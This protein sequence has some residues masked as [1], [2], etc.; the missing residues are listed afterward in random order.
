M[1]N[2]CF[3]NRC[4]LFIKECEK[5]TQQ[6]NN[7]II[8][9]VIQYDKYFQK[10]GITNTIDKIVEFYDTQYTGNA[11]YIHIPDFNTVLN[12]YL[13]FPILSAYQIVDGEID[14]L[15]LTTI[16]NYY[17]MIQLNPYYPIEN[18]YYSEITGLI[19]KKHNYIKSIGKHLN[20]VATMAIREYQKIFPKLELVYVADCR[21]F[22]SVNAAK[23]GAK[24]IRESDNSPTHARLIGYY[25]VVD[26]NNKLLE[27]PTFVIKFEM[28]KPLPSK[29]NIT[30][31]YK[32]S[33]NLFEDMEKEIREKLNNFGIKPEIQTIDVGTGIVKFYELENKDINI[34]DITIFTNQTDLGNDRIPKSK[35]LSKKVANI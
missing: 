11:D 21:N 25:T 23:Y 12:N 5:M 16:K 20:E 9:S 27:A 1:N 3:K 30:F 24:Y 15:G 26:Q 14:I 29:Q 34:E 7:G 35:V 22:R 10:L 13:N 19:A 18:A 2:L 31:N 28:N 6:Y 17:N 4:Q 8:F 32:Y 33:E